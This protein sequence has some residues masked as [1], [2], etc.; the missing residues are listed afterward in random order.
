[1]ARMDVTDSVEEERR[2]QQALAQA[3][4]SAE[5]ANKAKSEFLSNVSHD[6]RTPMNAIIGM[7]HIALDSGED[8]AQ[9]KDCLQKIDVSG[10]H[11]LGLINNVLDMSKIEAGKMVLSREPVHLKRLVDNIVASVQPLVAA[12][13]H[14]LVVDLAQLKATD[15]YSDGLPIVAMT[16]D[17]F[18]EDMENCLRAGMNAHLPKPIDVDKLLNILKELSQ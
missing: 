5:R 14:E 11:L 9:I 7:T 3:L 1:M 4:A 13:E 16:A 8:M 15:I 10:K 2:S 6:I 18:A 12:K 17:A